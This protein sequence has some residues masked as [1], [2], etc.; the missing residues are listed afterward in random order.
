[1]ISEAWSEVTCSNIRNCWNKIIS[2]TDEEEE[3]EEEGN[4]VPEMQQLLTSISEHNVTSEEVEEYLNECSEE[5]E[6]YSRKIDDTDESRDK[7]RMKKGLKTRMKKEKNH[8]KKNRK[9]KAT[10]VTEHKNVGSQ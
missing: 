1:M 7:T 4:L 5:G 2:K 3:Q 10:N 9:K 6:T 8:G